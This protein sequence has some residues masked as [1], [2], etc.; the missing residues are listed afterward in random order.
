[1]NKT[2]TS[3]DEHY[4][5]TNYGHL[6]T[7]TIAHNL[8]KTLKSITRKA[9]RMG[10]MGNLTNR[11]THEEIRILRANFHKPINELTALLPSHPKG[12]ILSKGYW[13]GLF[14]HKTNNLD[15]SET[16]FEPFGNFSNNS[17]EYRAKAEALI[18]RKL[19]KGECVH[20][21][22]CEHKNNDIDNLH[23]FSHPSQH[24]RAHASLNRLVKPL[25]QR[26][27][28]YFD[29]KDGIYKMNS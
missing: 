24:A 14:R 2:W 1:M 29:R 10:L 4:L 15:Y 5:F 3:E 11:W 27:I 17:K 20:H 18:E 19:D 23:V 9:E 21:I 7:E 26:G 13:I 25:L 8:N 6:P 22:D 12:S 16:N 28:I